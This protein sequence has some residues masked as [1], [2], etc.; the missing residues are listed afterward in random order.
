MFAALLGVLVAVPV[1]HAAPANNAKAT[2]YEAM[3]T[4]KPKATTPEDDLKLY[5]SYF[6]KKFPGLPL[7]EYANGVYAIDKDARDNWAA[8]E[9]FPP[10]EPFV[11]E[12]KALWDK[13]FNNGR[14]YKYCF[15]D[16]PAQ[17]KNFPYFD[18]G[19]KTVLT[20]ELAVNECLQANGEEPLKYGKGK[21]ASVLAYMAFE[22]RGQRTNVQV[23]PE[24]ME[25]YNKGKQFYFA[26]RGQLSYSCAHCHFQSVGQRLRSDLLSPA[27]GHTTGWPVYRAKWGELG[28]LHRRFEGCNEQ[29]RAAPFKPQGEEYRNLEFFL[30]HM[31]NGI[32]F[33]GPSFRK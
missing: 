23:T 32:P 14:G 9:E 28:T 22:S 3:P 7:D 29:V 16:G 13:P 4:A 5:R 30:A 6:I 21:M 27:L 10:Y 19:R 25:A 18:K 8:M 24:S 2:A 15:P 11:E 31:S 17:N 1:V 26:R 12:G 33:N 20:L